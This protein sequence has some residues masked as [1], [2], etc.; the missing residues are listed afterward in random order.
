[1]YRGWISLEFEGNEDATTGVL[2]SVEMLKKH[3]GRDGAANSNALHWGVVYQASPEVPIMHSRFPGMNPY[4][5]QFWGDI[6][7]R[8]ITYSSDALQKQ[9]PGDLRARVDERVF[10]EP[11]EGKPRNIVPD[12]RV[13]ERGRR[14]D[15]RLRASNGIAVAEPLIIR[16]DQ[17]EPIRQGFIEIIDIKSGRRVVTVIEILSPSNKVSGPGR[18]LYLKK[19][20]E[21]RAAKVSLVEIDLLRAG[22]RVLAAPLE[23]IPD[24]HRTPY[25]ACVRRGWKALELEYYRLPLQDRLPA[26]AIPLRQADHDVALDLQAL[27]DRCYEEA[28]YDEDIDYLQEPDPPLDSDHARW[29]DDLL[30]K[31]G[32]R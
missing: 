29:A 24:G 23:L 4:L 8:L 18:D 31:H 17:N 15:A 32:R 14:D 16:L 6:H 25:A 19:Q 21:L 26:I 12:V 22:A 5:E 2:K 9:L 7:H 3:F 27:I 13:V 20:E 1:M 28:R 30:R 11:E 10:V